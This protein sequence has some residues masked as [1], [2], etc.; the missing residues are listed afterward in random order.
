MPTVEILRSALWNSPTVISSSAAT[1]VS[2][3][4]R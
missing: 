4:V 2:F 3:G 1:S